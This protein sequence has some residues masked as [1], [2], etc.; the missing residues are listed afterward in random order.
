MS[1]GLYQVLPRPS[2]N[3]AKA[4]RHLSYHVLFKLSI[5]HTVSIFSD[6]VHA[7][8]LY[9][10]T[11]PTGVNSTNTNL[12]AGVAQ[13]TSWQRVHENPQTFELKA[14]LLPEI[15]TYQGFC[16]RMPELSSV[17]RCCSTELRAR[18]R[19]VEVRIFPSKHRIC[20]ETIAECL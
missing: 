20:K 13:R 9:F 7:W 2:A 10:L 5:K 19:S 4:I 14:D 15:G 6:C 17:L 12:Q 8:N 1:V 3:A 11:A 18:T 16:P